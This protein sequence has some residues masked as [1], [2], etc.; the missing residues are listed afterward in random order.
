[1]KHNERHTYSVT[2]LRAH[3]SLF[4]THLHLDKHTLCVLKLNFR[5][6]LTTTLQMAILL[7]YKKNIVEKRVKGPVFLCHTVSHVPALQAKYPY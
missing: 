4:C 3:A 5:P 1:M 6:R 2:I 7:N